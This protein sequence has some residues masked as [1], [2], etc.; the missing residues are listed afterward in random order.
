VREHVRLSEPLGNSQLDSGKLISCF[1]GSELMRSISNSKREEAS[2]MATSAKEKRPTRRG[3][4]SIWK[5]EAVETRRP[6]NNVCG[7]R[8]SGL[9]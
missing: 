2:G 1:L 8:D 3:A 5:R 7:V 6:E 4:R 9:R